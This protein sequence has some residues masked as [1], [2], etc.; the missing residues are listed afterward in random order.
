MKASYDR[1]RSADAVAMAVSPAAQ[2]A[3][4]A[5]LDLRDV[6]R[7]VV[8]CGPGLAHE[9]GQDEPDRNRAAHL[10]ERVRERTAHRLRRMGELKSDGSFSRFHDPTCMCRLLI[11]SILIISDL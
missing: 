11:V 5:D 7:E 6:G 4:S 9:A 3:R 8:L 10:G 2:R 1:A